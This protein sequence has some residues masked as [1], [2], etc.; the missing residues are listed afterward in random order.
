MYSP[1]VFYYLRMKYILITAYLNRKLEKFEHINF[2]FL[3]T[4]KGI[5][6]FNQKRV[7]LK[8]NKN[9]LFSLLSFLFFSLRK[10]IHSI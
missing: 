3:T 5:Y 9:K 10:V 4:C 2:Y 1:I 6:K 7:K 8:L